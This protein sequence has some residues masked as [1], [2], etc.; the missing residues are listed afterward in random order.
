MENSS[1]YSEH[2]DNFVSTQQMN[3]T[4]RSIQASSIHSH[5]YN[6]HTNDLNNQAYITNQFIPS[7]A[8]QGASGFLDQMSQIFTNHTPSNNTACDIFYPI[9][10]NHY[11]S[12]SSVTSN[13]NLSTNYTP[14][15]SYSTHLPHTTA[16]LCAQTA[17]P[18]SLS[19]ASSSSILSNNSSSS[20]AQFSQLSN[21]QHRLTI[22]DLQ[23]E[24]QELPSQNKILINHPAF[25]IN[26]GD[27]SKIHSQPSRSSSSL[28]TSSSSN[29]N[30]HQN[31]SILCKISQPNTNEA[32]STTHDESNENSS[33]ES[34]QK[35]TVIY[36]W[37]KKVH[38]NNSRRSSGNLIY[39]TH[40]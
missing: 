9:N 18:S 28:S 23:T 34:H 4:S 40:Y 6:S 14:Y 11:S 10:N 3:L 1:N 29:S 16:F 27:G 12:I 35:P 17:S 32:I 31:E 21:M 33:P 7:Y 2:Y 15:S 26:Q 20:N 25:S 36:N 8:S 13:S 5:L 38:N 19:S 37:M 22:T 30:Y 24:K 39:H